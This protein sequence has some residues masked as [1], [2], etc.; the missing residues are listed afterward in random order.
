MDAGPGLSGNGMWGRG[1]SLAR[2]C[3]LVDLEHE[4]SFVSPAGAQSC[5]VLST[6]PLCQPWHSAKQA[7]SCPRDR[8][9]GLFLSAVWTFGKGRNTCILLHLGKKKENPRDNQLNMSLYTKRDSTD[10]PQHIPPETNK[11]VQEHPGS[12]GLWHG[13]RRGSED[14]PWPVLALGTKQHFAPSYGAG[15]PHHKGEAFIREANTLAAE[16]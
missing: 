1:N 2:C 13:A 3:W 8:G 15:K 5:S 14:I 6:T 11:A 7:P 10:L 16:I 12:T 9:P 4:T